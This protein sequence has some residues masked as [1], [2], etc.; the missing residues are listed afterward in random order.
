M[1]VLQ[2]MECIDQSNNVLFRIY[3][4]SSDKVLKILGFIVGLDKKITSL[5]IYYE[6]RNI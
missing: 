2:L 5:Q 1:F 6:K 4:H 3:E